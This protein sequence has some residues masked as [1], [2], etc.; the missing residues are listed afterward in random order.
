MAFLYKLKN[1]FTFRQTYTNYCKSSFGNVYFEK[2]SQSFFPSKQYD[3]LQ[4]KILDNFSISNSVIN[5]NKC[6]SRY[7]DEDEKNEIKKFTSWNVQE[8]WWYCYKGNKLQN[9]INYISNCD[10]DVICLQEV[11]EP[12]SIWKI[13]NNHSI[14][15][16]YPYYLTGNMH[17]RFILG[18][19][20]GL[21]VLSKKP[22][23]F[24]QFT[25]FFKSSCPD[26]YASKG[27]LYFSVGDYNFITTHLQ[28]SNTYLA[29]SQL[30]FILRKSP[31]N[32]KAILL[33]DLN[34]SNPFTLMRV[35][36]NLKSHSHHS[37]KLLDHVIS[38]QNDINLNVSVDYINL[39]NVSD[40]YP[41]N[42]VLVK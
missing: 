27:A 34:L 10:S 2:V 7:N 15:K 16:K 40:H 42:G 41:V 24:H 17:N 35:P 37:G 36:V 23:T 14:F 12:T 19:N 13:V 21:L 9:I 26:F 6:I 20:S 25:P 3:S 29:I 39:K 11:F 22:I 31:F 30:E 32:R 33:G 28:S 18:E 4:N 8:L 38:V 5:N 1:L